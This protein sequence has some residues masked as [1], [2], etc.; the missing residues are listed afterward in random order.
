MNRII[1]MAGG[2][3]GHIFPALAVAQKLRLQGCDVSWLGSV[4]GMEQTLVSNAG[5]EGDWIAVSGV[6]GK[7]LL[8]K[9]L[10][11]F[12][13]LGSVWQALGILR[14]RKPQAV[15]GM[16]GFA[17]GP[18][19]LAAWLLRC[20]LVIHEQN[21]VAGTTNKILSRLSR[22][23]FTAFPGAFGEGL[24][25]E[26][27]GNPVRDEIIALPAP[28][29]RYANRDEKIRVL[30]LGGSQGALSLN[31]YVPTELAAWSASRA[32]EVRHQAGQRTIDRATTAYQRSGLKADVV[33]FIDDMAE[34]YGW[35]DLAICRS[36]ALTVSELSASGV[37]AVLV[38]FPYAI[39]DHQTH[40]A[41][42]LVDTGAAQLLSDK[43][44]VPGALV[45]LLNEMASDRDSLLTMARAARTQSKPDAADKVASTCMQ[46][47]NGVA[48]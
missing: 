32:I 43:Q 4:G 17:S 28:A 36:G 16:G 8:T 5:F 13:L 11:P 45:G 29:Q 46:F 14:Q 31:E 20:P 25:S 21:A 18:G 22:K 38:P 39:D 12:K 42:F 3:G 23:V 2:T 27:V 15:L 9:L 6:R 7:G 24:A 10:A 33:P 34:A 47:A 41:R 1:V 19:G 37:A 30:V 40:N 26:V 35:A 48:A 44:C